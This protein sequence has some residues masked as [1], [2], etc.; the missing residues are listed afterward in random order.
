MGIKSEKSLEMTKQKLDHIKEAGANAMTLICPFCGVLYED[1]QKDIESK[2]EEKYGIPIL[3][4]PQLLGLALGFKS[5]EL[6]LDRNRV[7]TDKLL[8]LIDGSN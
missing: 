4:Y 5:S 8:E 7:K 1:Q 6:G 2:S 3:Y